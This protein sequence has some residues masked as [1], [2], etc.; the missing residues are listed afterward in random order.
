MLPPQLDARIGTAEFWRAFLF[1]DEDV[2]WQS[3][4]VVFPLGEQVPELRL[5]ADASGGVSLELGSGGSSVLLA[6]DDLAHWHPHLLRW[7]ELDAIG[8]RV[9]AE[10]PQ[11]PH[12]GVVLLLLSRF[13]PLLGAADADMALPLIEAAWRRVGVASPEAGEGLLKL[14]DLRTA[15]ARWYHVASLGWCLAQDERPDGPWIY[16]LRSEKNNE[17]PWQEWGALIAQL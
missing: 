12:P 13:A 1:L 2:P 6:W 17:F 9:E 8:R 16:S 10:S 5:S 15:G 3:W 14:I 7:C 11:H 4:E